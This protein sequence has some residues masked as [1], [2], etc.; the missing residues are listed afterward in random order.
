ML[1]S[2]ARTLPFILLAACGTAQDGDDVSDFDLGDTEG[3]GELALT[4]LTTRCS[5]TGTTA[6]VALQAGDV[7][8]ISK[9]LSGKI[10]INALPCS[11]ATVLTVKQL[12]IT[13]SAGADTAILDY[14]GGTFLP[15]VS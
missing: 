5:V 6:T 2:I 15:G 4:N 13:G 10:L 11:T 8:L 12:A 3:L 1:R 14:M 7:A 9:D